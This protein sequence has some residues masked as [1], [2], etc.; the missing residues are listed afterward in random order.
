M[1]G[2]DPVASLFG[3]ALTL[4][5]GRED[6]HDRLTCQRRKVRGR[7]GSHDVA[8]LRVT[9]ETIV[10]CEEHVLYGKPPSDLCQLGHR[11][12][13]ERQVLG[14]GIEWKQVTFLPT[15]DGPNLAV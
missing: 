2:E 9:G 8:S 5:A 13:G 4:G 7:A 3:D 6:L 12:P 11:Q 14:I 1:L 10:Q 15:L